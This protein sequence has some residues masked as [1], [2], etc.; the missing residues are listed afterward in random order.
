MR[1]VLC[2]VLNVWGGCTDVV[3]FVWWPCVV[4]V[5]VVVLASQNKRG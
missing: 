3:F 5:F 1:P 2:V 4:V